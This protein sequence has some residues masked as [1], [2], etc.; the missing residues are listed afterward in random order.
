MSMFVNI[1][2]R[3]VKM[4]LKQI[5]IHITGHSF[6]SWV[7]M[8]AVS[9][10]CSLPLQAVPAT[11]AT[12][13]SAPAG[14]V[15]VP[16]RDAKS[17][18]GRFRQ[19]RQIVVPK[20]GSANVFQTPAAVGSRTVIG[21]RVSGATVRQSGGIAGYGYSSYGTSFESS[22]ATS[23]SLSVPLVGQVQYPAVKGFG[24]KSVNTLQQEYTSTT[25]GKTKRKVYHPGA[26]Q[27]N[28][29]GKYYDTE[30]EDWTS[31]PSLTD[32]GYTGQ[33]KRGEDGNWYYWDGEKWIRNNTAE[34]KLP[35]GDVPFVLFFV[36]LLAYSVRKRMRNV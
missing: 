18:P 22:Y 21:Y 16:M 3:N 29:E 19:Q 36:L 1:I 24:Y 35:L 15:C 20:T 8:V 27:T 5:A 9:L 2:G 7:G 6:V 17:V 25:T 33:T 14:G 10:L 12:S 30:L 13:P 31:L 34:P 32:P 11:V 4:M 26:D 23:P 28:E